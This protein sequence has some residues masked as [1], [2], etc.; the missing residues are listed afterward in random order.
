[1]DE[2]KGKFVEWEIC[3]LLTLDTVFAKGVVIERRKGRALNRIWIVSHA[4][5]ITHL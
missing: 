2:Q 5:M 1:M 4:T 3:P